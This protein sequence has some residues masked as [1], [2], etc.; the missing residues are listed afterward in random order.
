M[1]RGLLDLV[2]ML[3]DAINAIE[4]APGPA[5]R[6]ALAAKKN[7]RAIAHELRR[8]MERVGEETGT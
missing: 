8:R 3:I 1:E 4:I 2:D 7:A 5:V 6:A